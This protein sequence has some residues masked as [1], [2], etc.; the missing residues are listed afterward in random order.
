ML[1]I[2]IVDDSFIGKIVTQDKINVNL[3]CFYLVCLSDALNPRSHMTLLK[4]M[5]DISGSKQGYLRPWTA[6]GSIG[7]LGLI[8]IR[9]CCCVQCDN[10]SHSASH[11]NFHYRGKD[12]SIYQFYFFKLPVSRDFRLCRGHCR[13]GSA[14]TQSI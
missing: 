3:V 8:T 4:F 2:C 12:F 11:H 13:P 10:Y 6:Q 1:H 5:S 9:H 14:A 7:M